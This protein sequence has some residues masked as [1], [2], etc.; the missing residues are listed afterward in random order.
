MLYEKADMGLFTSTRKLETEPGTTFNY[1]S[2]NSN[3]L[4]WNLRTLLGDSIYHEFPYTELFNKI[5]MHRTLWE[6]DESG[7]YVSSSYIYATARDWARF[8]DITAYSLPLI[9]EYSLPA[10]QCK[11]YQ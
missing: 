10:F 4:S 5:G 9:S 11:V 3:L 6:M 2:C 7:T 1:S 8:V